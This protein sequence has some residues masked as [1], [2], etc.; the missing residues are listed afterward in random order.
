MTQDYSSAVDVSDLGSFDANPFTE[1]AEKT[2][3][4]YLCRSLWMQSHRLEM[5]LKCVVGIFLE[6]L[7]KLVFNRNEFSIE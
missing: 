1:A 5:K 3:Y 6:I 4:S 7:W 2:D